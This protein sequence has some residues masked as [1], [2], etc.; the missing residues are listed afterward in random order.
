MVQL[1]FMKV[2]VHPALHIVTTESNKCDARLGITWAAQ[3]LARRSGK[4]RVQ[5][6]VDCTL[7]PFG[8][9]A[10]RGTV[11]ST[12][13]VAGALVV[14]KW[15]LAPESRMAHCVVVVASTLIVLRRM[16]ATR[17]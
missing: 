8:R 9:Q 7:S 3:A 1:I 5:V 13:M 16:E 2:T 4:L 14:K 10:M 17:V 15:L 11:A 12:M 6:Y